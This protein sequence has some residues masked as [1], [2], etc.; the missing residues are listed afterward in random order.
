[1]LAEK[2]RITDMAPDIMA[3][4]VNADCVHISWLD[5]VCHVLVMFGSYSQR[6]SLASR[7]AQKRFR[8]HIA[9]VKP[10][11]TRSRPPYIWWSAVRSPSRVR[12]GASGTA[13]G[14][15]ATPEIGFTRKF[16][17]APVS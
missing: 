11:T 8:G 13:R 7:G 15:W 4:M 2:I 3:D 5:A 12:G 14:R 17:A 9:S 10:E 16:L 1:M 6:Q